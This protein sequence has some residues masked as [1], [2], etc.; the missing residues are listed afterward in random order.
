MITPQMVQGSY[1]TLREAILAGNWPMLGA[2]RGKVLFLLDDNKQ[3]VTIYRGAR[4]SLEG[5]VMFV[6]TDDKSPVAAF[7]TIDNAAKNAAAITG[8]VKAGLIVHTFAD[9]DTREARKND[10]LRR[11]WAFASG[12][13]II[14]TD[15]LIA[16]KRIG[17][18][19]V[20][21][22]GGHVAQCNV[23]LLPQRCAGLD[24]ESG[25]LGETAQQLPDGGSRLLDAKP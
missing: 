20:Q 10:T 24:V 16:N 1:P 22:P 14:S 25:G 23:Q 18:Y 9:V 11:D 17:K 15:F 6:A 3:K 21:V 13:Q 12:A 8:G 4:A 2:A 19:E 5:R 7:M